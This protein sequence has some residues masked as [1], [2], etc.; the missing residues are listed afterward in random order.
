MII[1]DCEQGTDEWLAARA[2][3]P[4]A[5]MFGSIITPNG[6]SSGSRSTYMDQ[7]AYEWLI[8]KADPDAYTGSYW[9]K[10][11]Q[12][13]EDEARSYYEFWSD[14]KVTQVG[15]AYKDAL[16]Q[17]GCSPDGL[18]D[19]EGGWECKTPKGTTLVGYMKDNVFP[20]YYKP[21]VQGNMWICDRQWWDFMIYN[22]NTD[23][24]IYR[25]KRDEAYIAKLEALMKEFLADLRI[26][27]QDI[28]SFKR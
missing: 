16:R 5:S 18:I 4:T 22:P 20:N 9:M 28:K 23:P 1:L 14:N 24:L 26:L 8:G 15:F 3:I 19:K 27:R 13:L 11:G 17:V 21:Q 10:R 12:E 25:I 6:A 7:L 2:G